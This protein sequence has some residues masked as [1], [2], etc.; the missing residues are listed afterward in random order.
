MRILL[1][2]QLIY[3][4]QAL[5]LPDECPPNKMCDNHNYC[6]ILLN[7]PLSG[8]LDINS[9]LVFKYTAQENVAK[10]IRVHVTRDDIRDVKERTKTME[11]CSTDITQCSCSIVSIQRLDDS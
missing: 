8:Y 7:V 3:V 6:D 11:G 2:I 4:C 9:T 5:C 10:R 1:S